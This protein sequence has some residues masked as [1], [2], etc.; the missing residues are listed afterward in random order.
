MP[1]ASGPS[2]PHPDGQCNDD[3]QEAAIGSPARVCAQWCGWCRG[4]LGVRRL[5]EHTR[6]QVERA[7]LE[8]LKACSSREEGRRQNTYVGE[9]DQGAEARLHSV[10]VPRQVTERAL[11]AI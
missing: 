9:D 5:A 3:E 11:V 7:R 6:K 4:R 10:P 2:P 1:N 8:P